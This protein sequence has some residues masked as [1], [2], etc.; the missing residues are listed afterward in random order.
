MEKITGFLEKIKNIQPPDFAVRTSMAEII[1][2]VLGEEVSIKDI[3]VRNNIVHVN[4]N[5]SFRN[6][7]ILN[8]DKIL[9]K[10][11]DKLP[12][13]FIKDIN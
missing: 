5:S 2:E 8:K 6:T 1:G 7:P 9:K 12:G 10:L 11:Q 4:G 13:E 3:S